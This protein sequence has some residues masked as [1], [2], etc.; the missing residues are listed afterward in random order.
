M[1]DPIGGH[2]TRGEQ[3]DVLVEIVTDL[4]E[5]GDTVLDLGCGTGYLE[6]LLLARRHDLKLIGVDRKGASLDEGRA[7]FSERVAFVEGDLGDPEAIRLPFDRA[8]FVVSALTFHDLADERKQAVLA[9]ARQRL[10]PDGMI[11]LYDRIRL[12][13]P[14]LFPA[15]QAIWRRIERVHGAAMRTADGFAAYES[16]LSETNRPARLDDYRAWFEALGMASQVLHLHGNV[17]LIGAA[18]R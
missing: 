17:A 5:P 1:H 9:W 15:Q 3:L 4:A 8:R 2:P 16:D 10:A 7:R 18:P 14:A 11:L 6:H 12:T 13:E